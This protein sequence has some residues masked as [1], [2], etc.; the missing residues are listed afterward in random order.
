MRRRN[1]PA[2]GT[3]EQEQACAV[4][5]SAPNRIVPCASSEVQMALQ[6]STKFLVVS[7]I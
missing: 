3:V 1:L 4:Q 2:R 5:I 6:V 7:G